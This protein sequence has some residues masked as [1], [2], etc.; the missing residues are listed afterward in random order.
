MPYIYLAQLLH[1]DY[2]YKQYLKD[3]SKVS[4]LEF[5]FFRTKL[6]KYLFANARKIVSFLEDA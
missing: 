1:S 6:C 2:G 3:Y 5:G 4:L